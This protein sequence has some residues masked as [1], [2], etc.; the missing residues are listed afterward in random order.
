MSSDIEA[1]GSGLK[2]IDNACKEESVP[3][4]FNVMKYGFA[5]QLARN[6]PEK[7]PQKTTAAEQRII[8]IL[9]NNPHASRATIAQTLN[10]N[11]DTIKEQLRNLKRKGSIKRIGPDKGGYWEIQ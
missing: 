6:V 11:K 4:S 9:T 3:V 10:L 8:T 5:V 1:W 2:R 7:T